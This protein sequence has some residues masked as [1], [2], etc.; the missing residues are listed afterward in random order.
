MVDEIMFNPSLR[1]L[2][3]L[4]GSGGAGPVSGSSG[5]SFKEVMNETLKNVNQ[6]Q[7]NAAD[8]MRQSFDPSD[9]KALHEVM[10]SIEEANIAFLFTMEVRNRL[11]D[12]YNEVMRM[13]V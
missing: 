2:E 4:G 3:P 12:A 6:L 8:A 9:P 11:M 5:L 7:S 13:Q 1:P 10:V